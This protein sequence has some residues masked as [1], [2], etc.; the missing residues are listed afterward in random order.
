LNSTNIN[1]ISIPYKF[2]FV[3]RIDHQVLQQT[4][5][6]REIHPIPVFPVLYVIPFPGIGV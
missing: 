3:S 4:K 5:L 2:I 6:E 1:I